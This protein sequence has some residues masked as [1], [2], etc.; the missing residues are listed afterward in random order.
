L[1]SSHQLDASRL[2][3]KKS[4]KSKGVSGYLESSLTIDR[5]GSEKSGFR[6]KFGPFCAPITHDPLRGRA[7]KFQNWPG[8]QQT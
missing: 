6:E 4:R 2:H 7:F 5:S 1:N 8:K 3:E